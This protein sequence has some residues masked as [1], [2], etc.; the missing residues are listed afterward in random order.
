MSEHPTPGREFN[1]RHNEREARR[2]RLSL[3]RRNELAR[4]QLVLNGEYT[5]EENLA[6]QRRLKAEF[7]AR[8]AA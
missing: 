5:A 3:A 6:I 2:Q 1:A 8:R 7:Y 4:K